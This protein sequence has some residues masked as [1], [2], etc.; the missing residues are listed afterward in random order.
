MLAPRLPPR[1]FLQHVF[2]QYPPRNLAKHLGSRVEPTLQ[3]LSVLRDLCGSECQ[4]D[5]VGGTPRGK[6]L[7]LDGRFGTTKG[8]HPVE[9]GFGASL[10]L[11]QVKDWTVGHWLEL[12]VKWTCAFNGGYRLGAGE[13][14]G[15]CDEKRSLGPERR[16]C[17][18][19]STHLPSW[20]Q[21]A[22]DEGCKLILANGLRVSLPA[23]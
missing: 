3:T 15:T 9:R 6:A 20:I 2:F 4:G 22:A 23:D 11:L 17:A 21:D 10:E 5:R 14:E 16:A 12:Q 18:A 7:S 13:L 1:P 19:Q 8:K